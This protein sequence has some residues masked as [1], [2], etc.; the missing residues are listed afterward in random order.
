MLKTNFLKCCLENLGNICRTFSLLYHGTSATQ[1]PFSMLKFLESPCLVG[2][3]SQ[4][5]MVEASIAS[6]ED[7]GVELPAVLRGYS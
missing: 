6:A 2:S 5:H 7:A 1:I 3:E 4:G